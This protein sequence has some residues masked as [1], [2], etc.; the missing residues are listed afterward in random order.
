MSIKSRKGVRKMKKTNLVIS[1]LTLG[2]LFT[3]IPDVFAYRGDP[4]TIGPNCSTEQHEAVQ[5]AI[6]N[7]DYSSWKKLMDGKGIARKIT[8]QNFYRFAEMIKLRL[9]GKTQEADQIR[10]ELGLGLR[11]GSG[12]GQGKGYSRYS[13]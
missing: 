8:E 7:K 2:L 5:T 6:K 9:E 4:S 1:V 10:A 11:N 12:A 3:L 13:R